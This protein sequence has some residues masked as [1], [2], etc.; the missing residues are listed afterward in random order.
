M[1]PSSEKTNIGTPEP[2]GA[3]R[4]TTN[5]HI[6]PRRDTTNSDAASLRFDMF[7]AVQRLEL[8]GEPDSLLY[9]TTRSCAGEVHSN[10][11]LGGGYDHMPA[12]G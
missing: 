11:E 12:L 2:K 3:R 6:V 9:R 1:P 8:S 7:S 10:D 4:P 5:G